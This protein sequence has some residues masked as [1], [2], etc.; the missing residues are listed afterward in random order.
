MYL[1]YLK[2]HQIRTKTYSNQNLTIP[3]QTSTRR[4]PAVKHKGTIFSE[5]GRA[6]LQFQDLIV[7]HGSQEV[8]ELGFLARELFAKVLGCEFEFVVPGSFGGEFLGNL[9]EPFE[10]HVAGDFGSFGGG[11][12]VSC[13]LIQRRTL[14]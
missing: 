4:N 10:L 6:T 3:L 9:T 1:H 13:I 14:Q 7:Q 11:D 2:F 12:V 8:L 5:F